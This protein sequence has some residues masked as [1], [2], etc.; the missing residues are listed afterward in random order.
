MEVKEQSFEYC[1]IYEGVILKQRTLGK[2]GTCRP[3]PEETMEVRPTSPVGIERR[4]I[5][6]RVS[7]STREKA[8]NR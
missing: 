8:Y 3:K 4:E 2:G 6:C 5:C 7:R 1:I